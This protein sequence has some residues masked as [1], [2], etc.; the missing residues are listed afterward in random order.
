M[1]HCYWFKYHA[2]G[3]NVPSCRER[4]CFHFATLNDAISIRRLNEACR[5]RW[6]D[7]D[8]GGVDVSSFRTRTI[9]RVAQAVRLVFI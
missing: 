3:L 7:R 1:V 9:R 5:L 8:V 6:V 4:I 2:T